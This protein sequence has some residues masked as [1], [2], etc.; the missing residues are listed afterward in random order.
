MASTSTNKQPLLIDRVFHNTVD[1]NTLASGSDT[2]LDILGT[3]SSAVLLNC[4]SNDGGIIEDI[5]T[6]ARS[7]TSYTVL[8][9]LSTAADY[10]RSTEAAFVGKITT[11]TSV[12]AVVSFDDSPK[13]LAPV[14][15]VGTEA[16]FR[17]LYVPSGKVLWATLQLAIP[18]ASNTTPIIAAQGGLY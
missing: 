9:Y 14:P 7:D 16:Q 11:E 3:N 13:I 17:A 4:A 18:A 8:L 12:G 1:S 15:E 10:L 5:Y 6:V 2:S